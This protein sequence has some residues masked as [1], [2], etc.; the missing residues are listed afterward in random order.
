MRKVIY[1]AACSLDGF[2]AGPGGSLDWLHWSADVERVMAETWA[3]TDTVIM[4]RKTWEVSAAMGNAGAAIPGVSGYVCSR[5]LTEM[6]DG[7][8]ATLITSDAGDFVRQL[9]REPG[10]E[11]CVLGGGILA[12]S[13]LAAGVI[14]EVGLNIHPVLLGS[15]VP[16]LHDAGRIGLDLAECRTLDGGCI[17]AIYRVRGPD[18][19][20]I[21]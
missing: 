15:G 9:K 13:L 20:R 2:I 11:I 8:G 21:A 3:R 6:P 16:F 12:A 7:A 19:P 1:G 17:L 18:R 10:R 4:G 14:D 5:T